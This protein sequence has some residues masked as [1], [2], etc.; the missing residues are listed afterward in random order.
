[1]PVLVPNREFESRHPLPLLSTNELGI[2][3]VLNFQKELGFCSS[4]RSIAVLGFYV[5]L[6]EGLPKDF[7]ESV[8]R[9][10]SS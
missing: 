8:G 6:F 2:S 10:C 9:L 1:M 4:V 3:L 5:V 7:E